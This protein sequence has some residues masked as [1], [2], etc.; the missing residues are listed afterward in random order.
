MLQKVVM[1]FLQHAIEYQLPG[2]LSTKVRAVERIKEIGGVKKWLDLHG[3]Q[4]YV[5]EKMTVILLHC[6]LAAQG[7]KSLNRVSF[8]VAHTF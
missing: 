5:Q 1:L 7:H 2:Q 4:Q 3:V 6:P 8:A